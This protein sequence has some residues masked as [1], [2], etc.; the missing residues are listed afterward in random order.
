MSLMT[1]NMKSQLENLVK[2][3]SE[4]NFNELVKCYAKRYYNTSEV[5]IINGPYDGGNDLVYYKNNEQV[6]RNIQ[7]TIQK[8]Q[9]KRKV[10]S[11]VIKASENVSEYSYQANLDFYISSKLTEAIKKELIRQ[12]EIGYSINLKFID[13][14]KIVDDTDDFPEL[15]DMIYS[16]HGVVLRDDDIKLDRQTRVLLNMLTI[17]DNTAELKKQFIH[18]TLLLS[19]YSS[20]NCTIDNIYL[21]VSSKLPG[22]HD[23]RYYKNRLDYL[24]S[25]GHLSIRNGYYSLSDETEK[26][27]IRIFKGASVEEA[28]LRKK[29]QEILG[30]YNLEDLLDDIIF[31][32]AKLYKEHF[33]F[34]I[35]EIN[36]TQ[37][38]YFRG[39]KT[40]ML[41]LIAL[42]ERKGGVSKDVREEI[43]N[44]LIDICN[45]NDYL[46]KIGMSYMYVNLLNSN[47]LE[48]YL[49]KNKKILVLDTQILL[50]M[51]CT[52]YRYDPLYKDV[53]YNSV[54]IFFDSLD[55]S[56]LPIVIQTYSIYIDEVAGHIKQALSLHKFLELP[57]FSQFDNSDNVFF[58]FWKFLK[59]QNKIKNKNLKEFIVQDIL[60]LKNLP[61]IESNDFKR[62]LKKRLEKLYQ[63]M[64]IDVVFVPFSS[65]GYSEIKREYEIKL[66]DKERGRKT[67]QNDIQA[68]MFLGDK[69][70]EEYCTNSMTEVYFI[71]WDFSFYDLREVVSNID[72]FNSWYIYPPLKF[73]EKIDMINLKIN[74]RSINYNLI[75]LVESIFNRSEINS[76]F[77]D[78]MCMFFEKE[79][80]SNL[81]LAQKVADLEES[82]LEQRP[83]KEIQKEETPLIILLKNIY[84][85]YS[86]QKSKFS[87]DELISTFGK[88]DLTEIIYELLRLGVEMIKNV[89]SVKNA[90]YTDLDKIIEENI[91]KQ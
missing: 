90:F 8:S 85:N 12:A 63:L 67:V 29:I 27:I 86:S 80:I 75:S 17:S 84:S 15:V 14:G 62:T 19:I 13:G 66:Y 89:K 22:D 72:G 2:S 40:V 1:I 31:H 3:L 81:S 16:F 58:N 34:E 7:I 11:D 35:D 78:V 59:K 21:D 20:P 37:S 65:N 87:I 48:A 41:E 33:K 61:S 57:V 26:E 68:A 76:N 53:Q 71:S 47:K 60:G 77:L 28:E 5:N 88:E 52:K 55:N 10:I 79:D 45:S 49:N 44:E 73:S 23:K 38:S 9:I 70:N 64:G 32:L 25:K 82:L 46:Q 39:L 43:A 69:G 83:T 56:D 74:P 18:S 36:K 50:R 4:D 91:A 24:N 51:L 54:K 6:K 30:K 42:L